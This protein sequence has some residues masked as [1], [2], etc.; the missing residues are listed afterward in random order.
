MQVPRTP[1]LARENQT[2]A[3]RCPAVVL[4]LMMA[5]RP[6]RAKMTIVLA[7][8]S[9]LSRLAFCR[10]KRR[11]RPIHRSSPQRSRHRA[12]RFTDAVRRL[13]GATARTSDPDL[14]DA[15]SPAPPSGMV[16]S[17]PSLQIEDSSCPTRHPSPAP[18][19]SSPRSLS[20]ARSGPLCPAG[21]GRRQS[22]NHSRARRRR[23][24]GDKNLHARL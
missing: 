2:F 1:A 7:A 9:C 15:Q 14:I 18:A 17:A 16:P 13:C 8:P 11:G 4:A 21:S 6:R 10:R 22:R 3:V 5:V 12:S 19:H 23:Q 24:A 20:P